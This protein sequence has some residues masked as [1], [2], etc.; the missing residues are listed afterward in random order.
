MDFEEFVK[1]LRG[2]GEHTGG[3]GNGQNSQEVQAA[4]TAL[5]SLPAIDREHLAKFVS[6]HPPWVPI[7]ASCVGLGLEQLKR[8]LRYHLGS[9]GWISLARSQA[10][11]LIAVLDENFGLVEAVRTQLVRQWTFADVLVDRSKWSRRRARR[12]VRT[13]RFLEDAVEEVIKDLGLSYVMRGRFSGLGGQEAPCDVAIPSAGASA[14]I[15]G[16]IKGFDSTGSKLT[17]AVREIE[18][19]AN[20]RLARQFV[21][22]FIDGIGWLGRQADLKRIYDLWTSKAIDGLY[23][24]HHIEQFRNELQEMAKRFSLTQPKP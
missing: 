10:Q 16:A 7:L 18:Q 14:L 4:V 20:V 24:L 21:F 9:S 15:V 23:S 1:G 12:S 6:E 2:L 11:R 17:D 8:Q 13:G 3:N 22:A 5:H 19:M